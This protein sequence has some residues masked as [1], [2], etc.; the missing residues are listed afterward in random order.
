M[1]SEPPGL[2][3]NVGHSSPK[4]DVP[5]GRWAR[6]TRASTSLFM[7]LLEMV[8]GSKIKVTGVEG[9]GTGPVL[10]VANHFTRFETFILPYIIWSR[11]GRYVHS[12]AWHGLFHGIFGK[13]L[14]VMGAR[15]TRNPEIRHRMVEELMSGQHDWLIYPE[16]SMVK[17]KRIWRE[18]RFEIDVPD[19]RGPPH[20]G[21][22]IMAMKAL[23]YRAL[24]L[25]AKLNQDE[26]L[27]RAYAQRYHIDEAGGVSQQ[28]LRIVP[29]TITYWPLRPE[30]NLLTR[31]VGRFVRNVPEALREE[32]LVEGSL[33]LHRTDMTVHLGR[34]M[35]IEHY[36][37]LLHVDTK[38]P[39]VFADELHHVGVALQA[40]RNR[41]TRRM[42][43]EIYRKLEINL[44]HLFCAILHHV[45]H[46]HLPVN[47]MRRSIYLAARGIQACGDHR[48]HSSLRA[49]LTDLVAGVK[50][51]AYDS[52]ER[53]AIS[54]G[55][56]TI[57]DG[58]DPYYRIN[59]EALNRN[60]GFH[61]IRL[62]NT[63]AVIANELEPVRTAIRLI[64]MIASQPSAVIARRL[65][66]QLQMESLAD[67][68]RE[69]STCTPVQAHDV[70]MPTVL[71]ANDARVA[72][73]LIH[74]YMAS[75]GEVLPLAQY[76]NRQ[77]ITVVVPRLAGHGS[78]PEHLALVDRSDWMHSCRQA[79]A[80]A[81][82]ISPQVVCAG[83][84]TGGLL[85]LR[86]AADAPTKV[87][88]ALTINATLKLRDKMSLLSR[89][90]DRW[91]R[92][93][94]AL[95]IPWPRLLM[96]ANHAEWPDT[97]YSQNPVHGVAELMRLIAEVRHHPP[98]LSCPTLLLQADHDGVVDPSSAHR[99]AALIGGE[100]KAEYMSGQR[101]V[102]LR[103]EGSDV[104]WQRIAE[105]IS[106]TA[107]HTGRPTTRRFA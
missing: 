100:A 11:T 80:M 41:L 66:K 54:E 44:D 84:S 103:G 86:L 51:S 69:R 74:G 6:T 39:G 107:A 14:L 101:H 36:T 94:T 72:V 91:N 102:C 9:L 68:S 18:G 79:L 105:F 34:P 15:P 30:P 29:I 3:S 57:E 96:L 16:G 47:D 61:D 27:Q 2:E 24:Y 10:F 22:A 76:L 98:R 7:R 85:A 64:N 52:I 106:E 87:V 59:R 75:P 83:F 90:V 88:G 55:I 48:T 31:L 35:S 82:A 17:D 42:M 4:T 58:S 60:T 37:E 104:V 20:T 12:L 40:L 92:M 62:N 73:V 25:R 99:L 56:I 32:L 46:D 38:K 95:H 89:P 49:G 5:T 70:A 50:N 23:F 65:V 26:P 1:P 67:A 78:A 93:L 13:Y 77:G 21:A 53:L 8:I 71:V 43:H 28:P 81:K 45:Q 63:V 33:L 19:R 97:N